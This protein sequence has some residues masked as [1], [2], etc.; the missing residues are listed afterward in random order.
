MFPRTVYVDCKFDSSKA[1]FTAYREYTGDLCIE[2][3]VQVV[4]RWFYVRGSS[5]A[6]LSLV[7]DGKLVPCYDCLKK[8]L[9]KPGKTH[10]SQ[11]GFHCSYQVSMGTQLADLVLSVGASRWLGGYCRVQY[12]TPPLHDRGQMDR[13]APFQFDF[14]NPELFTLVI[15]L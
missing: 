11:S 2:S 14:P 15:P 13:Y 3:D 10:R 8:T 9:D 4:S 1:R 6:P 12:W 7:V 5:A